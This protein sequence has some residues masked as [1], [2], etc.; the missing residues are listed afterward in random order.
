MKLAL[1]A[2]LFL[3]S[4]LAI[5]GDTDYYTKADHPGRHYDCKKPLD[6]GSAPV[7]AYENNEIIVLC[8]TLT[9]QYVRPKG[10]KAL[11]KPGRIEWQLNETGALVKGP[12]NQPETRTQAELDAVVIANLSDPFYDSSEKRMVRWQGWMLAADLVT[13]AYGIKFGGCREANPIF[14][15]T[16][17]LGVTFAVLT[18]VDTR[19]GA[20]R[21]SRFFTASREWE[22]WVP[23]AT[24]GAAAAW[25][26]SECIL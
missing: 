22:P 5:A 10:F 25:N 2:L 3:L 1:I 19:N 6:D 8:N 16:P 9:H 24:H 14:K 20:K 11:F 17:L 7:V 26:L 12:M 4:P 13:T 23:V 18:F 15:H 21:T